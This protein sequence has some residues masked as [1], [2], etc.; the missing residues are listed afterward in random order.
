MVLIVVNNNAVDSGY[1]VAWILVLTLIPFLGPVLYLTFANRKV[2]KA[3]RLD[4]KA[5]IELYKKWLEP[6]EELL[7]QYSDPYHMR[8][9]QSYLCH[10]LGN[11]ANIN[12]KCTYYG[13]GY[14]MFEQLYEDL[15][16]AKHFILMEYFIIAKGEVW[17]QILD[18]LSKKV[19]EGVIVKL[20]YDDFGTITTMPI[21]FKKELKEKGIDA[22]CFNPINPYLVG[23]INYR[24]HRKICV[25]DNKIGYMGGIN[26]ADEY[27]NLK[28]RFGTWKDS[29]VRIEG[30]AVWQYTVIF[31]HLFSSLRKESIDFAWYKQWNTSIE[32]NALVTSFADSPSDDDYT[33][34]Q[35]HL[36]MLNEANN[37]VY[38][39]APYLLINDALL[40]AILYTAKRGVDVRIITPG[41]PDKWYV[42]LVSQSYYARLIEAGVKVYEYTPGFIHSKTWVSDDIVSIVGS[43]NVDYRSYYLNFECNTLITDESFAKDCKKDYMQTL[44]VCKEITLQQCMDQHLVKRLIGAVCAVFAPLF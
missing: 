38:I 37:Y 31:L 22:L 8:H 27:A 42:H 13:D 41:V 6:S 7:Q 16:S 20:I 26:L 43:T 12:T 36:T 5:S 19:N 30:E 9:F 24:N 25:I 18:I 40:K 34:L 39:S 17:G 4:T 15:N 28:V 10:S 2:K 32:N 23:T 29:A 33:G 1:K 44:S 35:A 21:S 3:L 11:G 14:K